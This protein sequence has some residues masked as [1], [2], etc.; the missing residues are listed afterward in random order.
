MSDFNPLSLFYIASELFGTWFWPLVVIALALLY[1][2]VSG[3]RHLRRRGL[4]AGAPLMG[5]LVVGFIATV[6]ATWWVPQTTHANLSAFASLL[7]YLAVFA[8]AVGMGLGVFAL[9]FSI[10]ARKRQAKT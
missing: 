7:D 8:I 9:V 4:S 6:L 3:F 2:V 10:L 5:G 1:G